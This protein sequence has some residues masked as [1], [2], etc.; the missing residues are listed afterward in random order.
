[1]RLLKGIDI[2]N[3]VHF[4]SFHIVFCLMAKSF[5][6]I[7]TCNHQDLRSKS[8]HQFLGSIRGCP[9]LTP[10]LGYHPVQL[11]LRSNNSL[12][13]YLKV[14]AKIQGNDDAESNSWKTY[15]EIPHAATQKSESNL[16]S[17]N[18]SIS[19]STSNSGLEEDLKNLSI[20]REE[21]P[22]YPFDYQV[23]L[24]MLKAVLLH[25]LA[26]EQWNASRLKMCHRYTVSMYHLHCFPFE[27]VYLLFS[28][29]LWQKLL[30]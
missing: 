19:S 7:Y 26:S 30:G 27:I 11:Q 10:N 17:E 21:L 20:R 13:K 24:D 16:S 8:E 9:S 23:Y 28:F 25:V 15:Q 18:L 29:C 22:H 12:H 1:M 4:L 2:K 14:F 3:S 5:Q 6:G